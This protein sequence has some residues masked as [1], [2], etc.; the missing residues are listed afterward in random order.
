MISPYVYPGIKECF[1]PVSE[2]KFNRVKVTPDLILS[3]I[4]KNCSVSVED[5]LSKTR[6]KDI[7]DARHYFCAIM[8]KQLG[9]PVVAIGRYMDRDHTTVIHSV[10]TFDD[11]CSTDEGYRLVF[12]TIIQDIHTNINFSNLY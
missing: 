11:R 4:S 12:E 5:I 9:Y 10:R 1:R 3:I 2:I 8:R 7:V 6:K